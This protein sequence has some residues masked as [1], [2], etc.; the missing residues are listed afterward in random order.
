VKN[1]KDCDLMDF[2]LKQEHELIR[3]M[4]REFAEK[5]MKPIAA[6]CDEKS[7][8]P[9]ETV[10]MIGE[11]GLMG[12]DIPQKYG[13]GGTDT[14]SYVIAIE[15]LSRICAA[16]GVIVSVN[17]SLVC[18]PLNKFGNDGQKEKFLTPLASG[19]KL[20]AFGLTEPNAGTD[21]ASQ[22]TTAVLEGDEWVI[23]GTKTFITNGAEADTIITFAMVDKSLKHKGIGTFIVDKETPGFHAAPPEHKLGIR[24]SSTSELNYDNVRIPKDNLL[25]KVG[26]GFKIAMA[27]LDCGRIGIAA[28]AVGI[29]QAS[30]E[31]SIE[32]SKTREQFGQPI[33]KFQAIQWMLADMATEI[34]ASRLLLY[35]AAYTK[36]TKDRFSVESAMAK[37]FCAETAMRATTKAVQ[38][39]G[40]YGYVKEYPIER[41]FRDA[42]ITE[43]YEGTSEV[44]RMVIAANLLK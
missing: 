26:D 7:E 37:L 36:D 2:K 31:D 22:S 11:L 13:G 3:K 27:T 19:K 34:E 42:K 40:G 21:A 14:I 10:K 25:G 20:G 41:Y 43:I 29:A 24:A 32:Y 33:G 44:Q 5:N 15:E 39:H 35:N 17:N 4:V 23:N 30:L 18:Y 6:E 16:T 1:I 8:F 12:M 38:I 9:T 28:Q